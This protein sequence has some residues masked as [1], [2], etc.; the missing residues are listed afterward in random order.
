MDK[1]N[2]FRVDV[3]DIVDGCTETIL[4]NSFRAVFPVTLPIEQMYRQGRKLLIQTQPY[5]VSEFS[6]YHYYFWH[7]FIKNVD[8]INVFV[9]KKWK[10]YTANTVFAVF[11]LTDFTWHGGCYIIQ[12]NFTRALFA[13]RCDT[14]IYLN[15][16]S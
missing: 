10:E 15:S 14:C 5:P 1:W 6:C 9:Y 8:Y 13:K 4:Y 16:N 12:N 2:K 3:L 11:F 7:F